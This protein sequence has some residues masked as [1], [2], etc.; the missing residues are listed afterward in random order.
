[1]TQDLLF[2]NNFNG[3]R[4]AIYDMR[5]LQF[6]CDDDNGERVRISTSVAECLQEFAS[7]YFEVRIRNTTYLVPGVAH[8]IQATVHLPQENQVFRFSHLTTLLIAMNNF[9]NLIETGYQI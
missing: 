4:N 6:Y 5:D 3:P 7:F 8:T 1:M 9:Q 2:G